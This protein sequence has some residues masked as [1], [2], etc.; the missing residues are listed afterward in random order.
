[1]DISAREKKRCVRMHH[2]GTS[3]ETLLR[4]KPFLSVISAIAEY[5][6]TGGDPQ[7]VKN[8]LRRTYNFENNNLHLTQGV[9]WGNITYGKNAVTIP[10]A[11]IT[12]FRDENNIALP[13]LDVDDMPLLIEVWDK[14]KTPN[15][16]EPSGAQ[17]IEYENFVIQTRHNDV[18]NESFLSLIDDVIKKLEEDKKKG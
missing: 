12:I 17:R 2:H 14:N 13:Q 6:F 8:H 4:D 3:P 5:L 16:K 11:R 15:I 1:M 9:D 7:E 10:F 18:R